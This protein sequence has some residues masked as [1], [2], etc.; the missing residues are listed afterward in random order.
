MRDTRGCSDAA[1]AAGGLRTRPST[2]RSA[3]YPTCAYTSSPAAPQNA[4]FTTATPRILCDGRLSAIIGI[5]RESSIRPAPKTVRRRS[6]VSRGL[7]RNA[8]NH[9]ESPID[10]RQNPYTPGA[11]RRPAKLAGRDADLE[12]FRLVLDRLTD[13]NHERS[14]IFSGLRGVGKTVLLLEFD[15]MAREAGWASTDVQEVGGQG[16]FR[17]TLA[18]M[19]LRVLRSLSL[20]ARMRDRAQRALSVVKS[21]SAS[22]PGFSVKLDIDAAIGSAD[23]GDLEEDVADLLVE[24]GEVARAG[25]AG[26][27]FVVDEMQNLDQPSLRAIC[28]AF[29]RLSQKNLP[30]ALV[31]AGLPTLPV[32]LRAAKPYASRL[33]AYREVGQL[34]PPAARAALVGP[35]EAHGLAFERTAVEKVIE[36]SGGYPYFIQEY[37]RVLWNEIEEGPLRAADVD[38]VAELVDDSL[39]SDFF[40]PQFDLATDAEQRYL[41][42]TAHL[43]DGPY[44]TAEAASAAGYSSMGAASA[45]R[46]SL[47]VKELI[48]SPRRGFIDFTVP[49]FASYL[50]ALDR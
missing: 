14:L 7:S 48:W 34:P 38:A 2:A 19:S 33:F 23:S 3:G 6:Y 13:G 16:D 8:N 17:G 36:G 47:I 12:D 22:V 10:R 28:M 45:T 30:V 25:N 40:G 44:R 27:L 29:H 24:I 31:G 43:G 15:I 26:A 39:D 11:G 49:R 37:G 9:R 5:A 41:I 20:K 50:R 46:E 42:A 18:R 35:A 4:V 32:M 1:G 21:F